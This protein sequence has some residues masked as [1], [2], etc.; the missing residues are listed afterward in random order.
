MVR[1]WEEAKKNF[2]VFFLSLLWRG[3]NYEF[4]AG[5]GVELKS[6]NPFFCA[7]I[8]PARDLMESE[9]ERRNHQIS[10]TFGNASVDPSSGRETHGG[11]GGCETKFPRIKRD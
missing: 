8:K 9:K 5:G 4:S 2:S 3:K 7:Y 11:S 10:V 6:I 1:A